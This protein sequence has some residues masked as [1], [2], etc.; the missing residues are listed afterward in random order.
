MSSSHSERSEED[1]IAFL[2]SQLK[3]ASIYAGVRGR[4]SVLL[5]HEDLADECLADVCAFLKDGSCFSNQSCARS[6][7]LSQC[8][9][10]NLFE[11]DK[12]ADMIIM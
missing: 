11:P 5:I 7:L 4:P 6:L 2:H 1:A 8:I 9:F 12:D 3:T 10:T